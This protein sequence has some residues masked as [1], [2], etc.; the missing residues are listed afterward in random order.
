VAPRDRLLPGHEGVVDRLSREGWFDEN[1]GYRT[2]VAEASV[3]A[4]ERGASEALDR[5][6]ESADL[7]L[8]SYA[9]SASDSGG[10]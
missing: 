10:R 5:L 2:L 7:Q 1:P 8:R 9:E 6:T 3:E 4:R